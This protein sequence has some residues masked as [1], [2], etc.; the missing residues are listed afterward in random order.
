MHEDCDLCGCEI[1]GKLVVRENPLKVGP[2]RLVCDRGCHL[3]L[4][5]LQGR[6]KRLSS[7]GG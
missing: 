6:V 1:R 3:R 7:L 5:K 4:N 2:E